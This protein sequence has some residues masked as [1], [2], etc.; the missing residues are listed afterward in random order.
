MPCAVCR[1]AARGFSFNP[2]LS[3]H[4]GDTL[5][6]CS[7]AHLDH[8]SRSYPKMIDPNEHELAAME[9]AGEMAGEYLDSL[10]KSDLAAMTADEWR[11]LIEVICGGYVDRLGAIAEEM[12]RK[13]TAMRAS[14]AGPQAA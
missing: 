4:R 10:G 6:A 3:G 14:I 9:H 8:I 11:T 5:M 13:A 7:M 1:R 2:R 12:D